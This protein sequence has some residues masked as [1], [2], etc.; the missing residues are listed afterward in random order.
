MYFDV[1]NSE[2]IGNISKRI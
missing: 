2:S 1:I